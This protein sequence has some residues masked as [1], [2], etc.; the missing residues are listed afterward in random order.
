MGTDLEVSLC[1][2]VL[3]LGVV[4]AGAFK[5][6]EG[7]R[8]SVCKGAPLNDLVG[9][10]FLQFSGWRTVD[11]KQNENPP[12]NCQKR[13]PSVRNDRTSCGRTGTHDLGLQRSS[14]ELYNG[15]SSN[16]P[17]GTKPHSKVRPMN[18]RGQSVGASIL[19]RERKTYQR[20]PARLPGPTKGAR[21][22]S[23]PRPWSCTRCNASR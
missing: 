5:S 3:I 8:R 10:H 19:K 7:T 16:R 22:S 20:N 2:S 6:S 13:K 23:R 11:K 21:S 1:K 12:R 15:A 9:R 4:A 14:T 17:T 18:Q